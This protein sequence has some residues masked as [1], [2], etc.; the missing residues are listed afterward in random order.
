MITRRFDRHNNY[1]EVKP[2]LA[3]GELLV[4]AK[5]ENDEVFLIDSI[6]DLKLAEPLEIQKPI[7]KVSD[8]EEEEEELHKDTVDILYILGTPYV[9]HRWN[10]ATGE[11]THRFQIYTELDLIRMNLKKG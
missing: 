3:F 5:P 6:L 4:T 7:G 10:I 11:V 2:P 8:D 1:E 9:F